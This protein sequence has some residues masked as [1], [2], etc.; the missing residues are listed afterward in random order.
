MPLTGWLERHGFA[1]LWTALLAFALA[2]FTFQVVGGIAGAVVV[3]IEAS[4]SGETPTMETMVTMLTER[5]DIALVIN[6]VA[7]V[8]VFGGLAFLFAR[9]HTPRAA[10]FLR[11]R[12]PDWAGLGLAAAGWVTL[13]PV[14]QWLGAKNAAIPL[15]EWLAEWEQMQ[16]DMMEQLLMGQ[17]LS[18]GFLLLTV[19]LT[20]SICEE[21]FFRGYLQRQVERR[22]GVVGTLITVGVVFG[23]FHLRISQALPLITLGIYLCFVVWVTG[24]LWSGML[25]HLLNNGFAVLASAYVE[26]R[27]DLN[28]EDIETLAVPWYLALGGVLLTLGV[29][30]AMRRRRRGLTADHPDAHPTTAPPSAADPTSPASSPSVSS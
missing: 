29:A 17:D 8:L 11:L 6:T 27:P 10:G 2:W 9:M 3:V 12:T 16:T 28:V 7:Q 21:L 18:T 25:V 4:R 15:P 23:M 30:V 1:P 13:M 14:V 26:G 19:A 22:L 5:G 20:P 24:S